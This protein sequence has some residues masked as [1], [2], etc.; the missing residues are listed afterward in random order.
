VAAFDPALAGKLASGAAYVTDG[1]GRPAQPDADVT[2]GA[3]IR[4]VV[5]A[6]RSEHSPRSE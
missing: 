4:V 2:P 6:R 5:S 3:I 1:V